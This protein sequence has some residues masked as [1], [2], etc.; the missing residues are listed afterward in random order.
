M[1][2][3][4]KISWAFSLW[5]FHFPNLKLA[6]HSIVVQ[7]FSQCGNVADY[8]AWHSF[9]WL[10]DLSMLTNF[11]SFF[12]H[13]LKMSSRL[14]WKC[15]FKAPFFGHLLFGPPPLLLLLTFQVS[16]RL[17][18]WPS[19]PKT[20]DTIPCHLW[21]LRPHWHFPLYFAHS[22]P[23]GDHVMTRCSGHSGRVLLWNAASHNTLK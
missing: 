5:I 11:Y 2:L 19:L 1:F 23:G 15:F 4:C 6:F 21:L 22:L 14:T 10:G 7:V 18:A 16:E 8:L 17:L 12:V 13:F 3:S 20:W 9:K